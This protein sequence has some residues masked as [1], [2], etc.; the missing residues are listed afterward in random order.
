LC[1]QAPWNIYGLSWSLRH[2]QPYRLALGSFIDQFRNKIS[3]VQLEDN[4]FKEVHTFDHPYPATKIMWVPDRV[5]KRD[6]L[7]A[8]SGD[9]LRIF[10]VAEDGSVKMRHLLNNNKSSMFCAPLTSFDW[11]EKDPTLIGTSS[12]DTTCTIWNVETGQAKTQLIAHDKEVYDFVFAPLNDVFASAG[13]DGSI[14]MFDLRSLEHST[15]LYEAP[16]LSPLLRLSWNN[17]DQNYLATMFADECRIVVLDVR[18]A[19]M[20]VAELVGHTKSI[21]AITWAPHSSCHL[22]SAGDDAQ[23][24]IWDLT[25]LPMSGDDAYLT[26]GAPEPITSL[27]WSASQPDWVSIAHG[28]TLDILRV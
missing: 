20:P 13:A 26:Y 3:I 9:Y 1:L 15:I 4:K 8:T 16:S 14:R 5:A 23:A 19:S 24:L 27:Q 10:K 25:Q 18:S 21:N 28:D 22:A 12:I 6:D 11:H 17:M 2:D 7:F